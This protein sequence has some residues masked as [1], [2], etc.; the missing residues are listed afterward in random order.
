MAQFTTAIAK[1]VAKLTDAN[2]HT[3]ARILIAD[4]F[5]FVN[6]KSIF[7]AVLDEQ[8]KR[9]YLEETFYE[10]RASLTKK[11]MSEIAEG[12]RLHRE[13]GDYGCDF[14]YTCREYDE[15]QKAI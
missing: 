10:I 7:E 11:M 5:G 14:E 4:Y 1:K 8:E 15:I 13:G 3:Q 9:G 12:G 2:L 6:Y